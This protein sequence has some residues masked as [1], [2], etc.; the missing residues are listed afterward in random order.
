MNADVGSLAIGT[1]V[2]RL[3]LA[4]LIGK[5]IVDQRYRVAL[6]AVVLTLVGILGIP[7]VNPALVTSYLAIVDIGLMFVIVGGDIRIT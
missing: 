5:A 7:R 3:V 6:I 1:W 2:V 4:G